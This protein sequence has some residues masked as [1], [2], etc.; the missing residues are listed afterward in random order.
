MI[1]AHPDL[2]VLIN[3]AGIMRFETLETQRDL[4]DAEETVTTNLLG[5]SA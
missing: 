4:S 3:N 2:N 1:E 5:R